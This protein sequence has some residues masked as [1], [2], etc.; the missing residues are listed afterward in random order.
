MNREKKEFNYPAHIHP[1]FEINFIENAKGAQRVVGDS[2]ED[3]EN[4]DL[5]FI[6]NPSLEHTWL[7]HNCKSQNIKEITI[8][9]H[10][11]L[12][13][14]NLLSRTQF[15][16]I[17]KMFDEAVKGLSFSQTTISLIKPKIESLCN[18][19]GF[20]SVI[21]LFTILYEMSLSTNIKV[22]SSNVFAC[23]EE[24]SESRRINKVAEFINNNYNR[25]I[26]LSEVAS[27]VNM[28]DVA[29]CRFFRKRTSKSFVEYLN[30]VRTSV[31]TKL[32][33]DT[34]KP[35][36]EICFEC[37]FNNISNFNRCF[38]KKKG[39]TPTEFREYFIK[40]RQII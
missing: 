33:A 6:A 23:N 30:N 32:L 4:Y 40:T 15:K 7:T 29:F 24:S 19:K 37:G 25:E 27:L 17:K 18:K 12:F 28:S 39:C 5:C 31:A 20:Y 38:K 35:I 13:D 2:I 22:L 26:S 10:P 3:I 8:Q 34:T 14:K 36:S 11:D 21:E 16:P 9:F 1:E